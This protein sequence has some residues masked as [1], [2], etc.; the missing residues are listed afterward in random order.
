MQPSEDMVLGGA[1]A[2]HGCAPHSRAER[3][4]WALP[5]GWAGLTRQ[6][7]SHIPCPQTFEQGRQ[8]TSGSG[9]RDRPC[10]GPCL[11]RAAKQTVR[12]PPAPPSPER[13]QEIQNLRLEARVHKFGPTDFILQ[14]P[15]PSASVSRVPSA[16]VCIDQKTPL[17]LEHRTPR[18]E[19]HFAPRLWGPAGTGVEL[20][21]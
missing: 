7:H 18:P 8:A 12:A 5:G 20:W 2:P 21:V 1:G 3:V 11:S 6:T 4:F 17:P 13:Q 14:H 9:H 15:T 10:F 16:S 19:S